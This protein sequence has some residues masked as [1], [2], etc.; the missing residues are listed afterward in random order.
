M[1]KNEKGRQDYLRPCCLKD[2]AMM[3]DVKPRTIKVW[4]KPFEEAIGEKNG[5][6]YTIRQMEIIFEKLGEPT[7]SAA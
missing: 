1:E 7:R 2:L 6:Y 4:L 3:Y 5:R